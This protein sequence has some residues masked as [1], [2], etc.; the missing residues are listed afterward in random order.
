MSRTKNHLRA[1]GAYKDGYT[2]YL[3]NLMSCAFTS[4]KPEA[5]SRKF[6]ALAADQNGRLHK[7]VSRKKRS[8][9][10][11]QEWV[12]YHEH[13]HNKRKQGSM[14]LCEAFGKS[15]AEAQRSWMK[16]TSEG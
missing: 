1:D 3:R 14:M 2:E 9:I 15:R 13:K 12:L 8:V 6:F 5:V 11:I 4:L 10:C 16:M 7:E